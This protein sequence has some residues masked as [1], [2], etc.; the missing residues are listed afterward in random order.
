[1]DEILTL[2]EC[3]IIFVSHEKRERFVKECNRYGIYPCG[4]A[5]ER[6]GQYFYL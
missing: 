5:I 1:M 3:G 6:E 2:V 4:G